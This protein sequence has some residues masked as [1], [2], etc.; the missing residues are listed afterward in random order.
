MASMMTVTSLGGL[1]G[2]AEEISLRS[3][4]AGFAAFVDLGA[5]NRE[6]EHEH[7]Y[8]RC[9]EIGTALVALVR[10]ANAAKSLARN[11]DSV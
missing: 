11:G 1:F 2:E 4:S 8:E 5:P 6:H 9:A 3:D 10:A 7:E